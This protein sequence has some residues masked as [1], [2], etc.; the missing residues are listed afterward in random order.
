MSVAAGEFKIDPAPGR[1]R[2]VEYCADW[3]THQETYALKHVVGH[4]LDAAKVQ[5]ALAAVRQ[6]LFEQ[7]FRQ[8]GEPRLDAEDSRNLAA[9]LIAGEDAKGI[10]SLAKTAN[11]WQR[12]G[13][14]AALQAAPADKLLFIDQVVGALLAVSA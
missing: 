7:R 11:V 5:D 8:L 14:A 9:S 10:V 12:D 2:L 4:L 6:G 3:A 13:V 1:Q